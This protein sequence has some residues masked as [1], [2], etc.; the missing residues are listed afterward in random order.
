MTG[1][2]IAYVGRQWARYNFSFCANL[3]LIVGE[4][5]RV[6]F[7]D[8]ESPPIP[9][10]LNT[11]PGPERESLLAQTLNNFIQIQAKAMGHRKNRLSRRAPLDGYI[12]SYRGLKLMAELLRI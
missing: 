8:C 9:K 11:H 10:F 3:F 6:T 2:A 7:S 5:A 4:V 12:N 1:N